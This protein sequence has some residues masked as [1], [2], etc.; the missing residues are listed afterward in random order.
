MVKTFKATNQLFHRDD[1]YLVNCERLS[2]DDPEKQREK[3]RNIHDYSVAWL[4]MSQT[5]AYNLSTLV[6]HIQ[7]NPCNL[8]NETEA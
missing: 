3:L 1:L 6:A 7:K 2:A 8:Q 4:R 5:R